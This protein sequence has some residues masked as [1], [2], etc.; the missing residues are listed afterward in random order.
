MR[1]FSILQSSCYIL[2]PWT[3]QHKPLVHA[4]SWVE[5]IGTIIVS[6]AE[7]GDDIT[8]YTQTSPVCFGTP[9]T[10][11]MSRNESFIVIDRVA[12]LKF[13]SLTFRSGAADDDK[14]GRGP[15][16]SRAT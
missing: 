13:S 2:V 4:F 3:Y 10:I 15:D 9:P 7:G 1:K 14:M 16:Q 8:L 12:N 11:I 6:H 5:Y